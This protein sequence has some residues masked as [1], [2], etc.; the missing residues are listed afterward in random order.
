MQRM[1]VVLMCTGL[2]ALTSGL[3][4]A[5]SDREPSA[6]QTPAAAAIVKTAYNKHLKR[7]IVVDGRGRTLYMWTADIGGKSACT[8]TDCTTPWP[9]YRTVG[10]PVAGAGIS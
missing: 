3:A 7:T 8:T 4:V 10:A 1:L 5:A 9:A 6:V 2:A